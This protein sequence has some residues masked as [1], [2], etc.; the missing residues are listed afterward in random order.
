MNKKIIG[1]LGAATMA[2]YIAAP[3]IPASTKSVNENT[4]LNIHSS[5]SNNISKEKVNINKKNDNLNDTKKNSVNKDNKNIVT[6]ITKKNSVLNKSKD[7]EDVKSIELTQVQAISPVDKAVIKIANV[8]HQPIGTLSLNSKTKT[9]KF[10][11]GWAET[12]PYAGKTQVLFKISLLNKEGIFSKS[13]NIYGG[14]AHPES[15]IDEAFNNLP[16][17]YGD[18]LVITIV[19]SSS[20]INAS[21]LLENGNISTKIL[22]IDKTM[23]FNINESGINI[24]NNEKTVINPLEIE[25]VSNKVTSCTV[26]GRT[27]PESKVTVL[28]GG[29]T[30]TA[31]SNYVG[32]FEIPVTD[33]NGIKS[34]TPIVVCVAGQLPVTV[35]PSAIPNLGIDKASIVT[36]ANDKLTDEILNFNTKALKFNVNESGTNQFSANLIENG[37]A[38]AKSETAYFSGFSGSNDFKNSYFKYGDIISVYQTNQ[39]QID[40]GS[41][42]INTG[43]KSDKVGI[44][45]FAY[46]EITSNGLVE[47]T[48]K[49]LT[50]NAPLYDGGK[51]VNITGETKANTNVKVSASGY[52][53]IVR[54]NSKGAYSAEIPQS[55]IKVGDVVSVY[56][57][58]QNFKQVI[59]KYSENYALG[60]SRVQVFN[61]YA[62][63]IFYVDFNPEDS[64]LISA[65]NITYYNY[66]GSEQSGNRVGTFYTNRLKFRLI[67][68][69]TGATLNTISTDKLNDG[70]SF[71]KAL[72]GMSYKTSDILDV[73]YDSSLLNMAVTNGKTSASN[74]F[75]NQ[76]F[77]I[78]DKGLVNVSN[79]FISTNPVD[80]IGSGLDS[81]NIKG[82]AKKDAKVTITVNGKEFKG[83]ANSKGEFDINVNSDSGFNSSTSIVVSSDGYMPTKIKEGYAQKIDIQN[84]H[85]NFYNESSFAQIQTS[86]GF[87][88]DN[89]QFTVQNYTDSFGKGN[90]KYF[91]L[92]LYNPNGT[93]IISPTDIKNGQTS[94][95]TELLNG[96]SYNYGDIISLSYNPN[97]SI[98]VI[99]NENS[100][101]ANINGSTQYFEITKSGLEKVNFGVQVYTKKV[102]FNN[103]NLTIDLS[104]AT[105]NTLGL[106]TGSVEVLD[107]ANNIE[108]SSKLVDGRV[109]FSSSQLEKFATGKEY[110]VVVKLSDKVLPLYVNSNI[111]SSSKYKLFTNAKNELCMRLNEINFAINNSGAIATY[112]SKTDSSVVDTI[113][114]VANMSDAL[115]N[116][117]S[118]NDVIANAFINRFG[119]ENLE[120]FYSDNTSN[121]SFINWILN[122][123]VAM[124]EYLQ[125]TNIGKANINSLQIWSDIWNEYTNSHSGF[126]LKL[127]IAT[128]L[129]NEN[130]IHDCFNG[131]AVGS[132]V[133]R[134]NIFETLN[135]QGGMVKGFDK[136]NVKFLEAVVDVPITNPQIREMRGLLLQNHNNLVRANDLPGTDYTIN[137]TFR[138]PYNGASIFGSWEKFYGKN[139]TVGN[140]FDIGGVCGSISRLGSIACRV[141]GQPSHQMGEPGH[142]AFYA[143]D[144]QNNTWYSE[145]G[146]TTTAMAT[147]F[148]VG[149]W[150]NGLA[151][152][153]FIVTY[154]ALYTK[155][156]NENLIKSNK[157]LWM[158]D[159]SVSYNL[160]LEAINKAIKAQ[161]LN[162][163][164]WLAKINLLNNNQNV[165]AKDYINL[166][167]DLMSALKD[168]P[169]PM[170][171]LLVK[172]NKHMIQVSTQSQYNN[173]IDNVTKN[174][175]AMESKGDSSQKA[176]AQRVLNDGYM[177]KYGFTKNQVKILGKI[178]IN[179]WNKNE[180]TASIDFTDTNKITASGIN[181][182]IGDNGNSGISIKTFSP[183]MNAD[184]TESAGGTECGSTMMKSFNGKTFTDGEIIEIIYRPGQKSDGYISMEGTDLKTSKVSNIVALEVTQNGL[185]VLDGNYTSPN[186]K[187]YN[188]YS[189]FK[190]TDAGTEYQIFG[191]NQTGFKIIDGKNYYFNKDGIMQ[192]G[193]QNIENHGYYLN[194]DG[195]IQTGW[196]SINGE[197]YYFASNGQALPGYQ[198]ID[199]KKYLFANN[200]LEVQSIIP[201]KDMKVVGYSTIEAKSTA[202]SNIIDGNLNT[203]WGNRWQ[204][205]SK[206]PYITL[207][208]NHK[209]NLN[210][211][212]CFPR[213]D[214]Y[215][216]GDIEKYKI[217]VSM[218]G[219]D[220]TPVTTGDWSYSYSKESQSVNLNG[221]KAKYI[222]IESEK[223]LSNVTIISEIVLSGTQV[224]NKTNLIN[225]LSKAKLKE[226]LSKNYTSDS[227]KALTNAIA[228]GQVILDNKKATQSQVQSAENKVTSA[229]SGLK[230][231][232]V[233]LID[234]LNIAKNDIKEKDDYT[235]ETILSLEKEVANAQKVIDNKTATIQEVSNEVKALESVIAGLK[236]NKTGLIKEISSA[237]KVLENVNG[238]TQDSI[239]TLSH[240]IL[241]GQAV[242]K[243]NDATI[244]EINVAKKEIE[245]AVVGLVVN[246][247]KLQNEVNKVSEV[248]KQESAYTSSSIKILENFDIAAQ[249]VL[250]NK[251]ATVQMVKNA[252]NEIVNAIKNLKPSKISLKDLIT[253][254]E[255]V[256]NTEKGYTKNSI[257]LLNNEIVSAKTI[258]NNKNATQD[259]IQS[260]ENQ[261]IS[262]LSRLK[263]GKVN[264]IDALNIAKND[265]KEKTDYTNETI[266]PLEKEVANAQ[267]V[268]DNKTATIQEVSNE[269]KALESVIAGLKVNKTGLSKEIS[270]A[271][272]VLENK[273]DYTEDSINVLSHAIL[274]GQAIVDNSKATINEINTAKKKIITAIKG[275]VKLDI[276]PDV[277]PDI[278]PDVKPD[279]KPDTKSGE[280]IVSKG[281]SKAVI[282]VDN[283]GTKVS[284]SSATVSIN[285]A[286]SIANDSNT[287]KVLNTTQNINQTVKHEKVSENK[288]D[289]HGKKLENKTMTKSSNL[290]DKDTAKISDVG[291]IPAGQASNNI[292][293]PIKKAEKSNKEIPYGI[294]IILAAIIAGL[295]I[296]GFKRR[297]KDEE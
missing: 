138:N 136:L 36:S 213:Q 177:T 190:K 230:V 20:K 281:S 116:P 98:P 236:V 119:K 87:N 11:K 103:E 53:T 107:S 135:K 66:G 28:L 137:Y 247:T 272:K 141:F 47:V 290:N 239:N 38:I 73:S 146:E 274:N 110:K 152:N 292:S 145:Y 166:S 108:I 255:K 164:A 112:G 90:E 101:I 117:K 183:N 86:I 92:G 105:G 212:V 194:K 131:K 245:N 257:D 180:P 211:L 70:S 224:V 8:W 243:N 294:G 54:S 51:S 130:T 39:S 197:N 206:V 132:P 16:F 81:T 219:K 43:T 284:N 71:V 129:A 262:A 79:K 89:K 49:D 122:N 153:S 109:T 249:N 99:L 124:S 250:N 142:D 155:A 209:Y 220:F 196:Q 204:N 263:V 268:I 229:L 200:G 168:Y 251:N 260:A 72:N 208:L 19:H 60:D 221:V 203:T 96:K 94:K 118:M 198:T 156:N 25:G 172:F 6:S 222:R 34:S 123:D 17:E 225:D 266:L 252:E 115:L 77:E 88:P 97:I 202:P 91:T 269:V 93:A 23:A 32:T 100:V 143:Y 106:E 296:F 27:L 82:M 154:T 258:L 223:G 76:Y 242:V 68:G 195:V 228:S 2:T 12:N 246:K 163:E 233:N 210:T 286:S 232:K 42:T 74:N 178:N 280:N 56:V 57:N 61:H 15:D 289:E 227:V 14:G 120:K 214:G 182:W 111:E 1:I 24:F 175:K 9:F 26:K 259:Q 215:W 33:E 256:A 22:S 267:M 205:P 147:G 189:G 30:F 45:K 297:K 59:Y 35:Y 253:K 5:E 144:I 52:S 186:G 125:A 237:R 179:S 158:A 244:S 149:N 48:N 161:P 150:S 167:N 169:E 46:Y 58:N 121:A 188:F 217:L 63:P 151:L 287:V 216:H 181:T 113:T 264:L 193:L 291:N 7:S 69:T 261:I 55:D 159:A 67:S 4:E 271:R 18:K 185:K 248:L 226:K 160:K 104:T 277:K 199:G 75:S 21:G 231:S 283:T 37:E 148:D 13:V 201:D 84:T 187:H 276:K 140:V 41:P 62:Q 162:V 254:A 64:K 234:A 184:L 288:I 176:Q 40:W 275:L 95:V 10:I 278:K 134:Y 133:E 50:V 240:S 235:N 65:K 171:D 83:N 139:S 265:I 241:N 173:F 44:E 170:F 157:Y 114:S 126:N 128:A 285:K 3:A 238:Y 218:N 192:I 31:K 29:K 80:V 85:I 127:A 174:L 295:L 191:E 78:T 282:N 102:S 273:K 279:I 207:E 165:T 270:L 293:N